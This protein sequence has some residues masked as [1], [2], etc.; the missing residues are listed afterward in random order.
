MA[1]QAEAVS[2]DRHGGQGDGIVPRGGQALALATLC[3]LLFLTFLDN[4]VVSVALG[5]IQTALKAN[6]AE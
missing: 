5:D 2:G 6:V 4:T 3:T 1:S